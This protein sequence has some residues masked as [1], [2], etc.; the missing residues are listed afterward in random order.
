MGR[1]AI[2]EPAFCT[3][4]MLRVPED[5][6]SEAIL[7]ALRKLI[8]HEIRAPS[9]QPSWRYIAVTRDRGSTNRLRVIS[10]NEGELKKLKDIVE[11]KKTLRAR[12]LRE[13]LYPVKVDNVNRIAVLDR[14]SKILPGTVEVLGQGNDVRIAKIAW[15]SRKDTVKAYGSMVV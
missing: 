8:E 14:E 6:A 9:N 4:D 13:W 11:A 15:L 1:P 5:Y 3:V 10:R 7:V 2:P 12:V